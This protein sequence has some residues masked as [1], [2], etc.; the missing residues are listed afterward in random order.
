MSEA[1]TTRPIGWRRARYLVIPLVAVAAAAGL[2]WTRAPPAPGPARAA[3]W[4]AAGYGPA[5]YAAG[6]Q[7]ASEQI[8]HAKERL[9][10]GPPDWLHEEGVA[11]ALISRSR[12]SPDYGDLAQAV[13]VIDAA[14]AMAPPNAGPSLTAAVIG[15]M[16]HRLDK[17]EAA[18]RIEDASAVPPE[19]AEQAEAA[20]LHGDIAFYRGDMASARTWY[21][22]AQRWAPGAGVA[23]RG[24]N[25]AKATGDYD[26]AI[27][28][29]QAAD[30]SPRRSG[31]FQ[32]ASTALQIGAVEQARGNYGAAAAWCAVADRPFP[33]F[34]LFQ[35]HRAQSLAIAGDMRG[36]IAA[37]RKVAREAPSAEVMDALA[38]LLR[39]D[40]QAAESRLWASRAAAIWDT[41]LRQLPQAAYGHALEHELVFGT[42]ARAL[43]LA[44]ANLA[45]RPFGE[46]RLYLASALLMNGQSGDAL[47]QIALAEETGWRS[48]PLYALRAQAFELEG[49]GDEAEDARKA[50]LALNPRIFAPETALVWFSHG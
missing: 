42:P 22:R 2:D 37:M 25:L 5:S 21:D 9:G 14:Q 45:A 48:A 43:A 35:A 4:A 12:L 8:D 6:L 24:A 11:R 38:M 36:A 20:G 47:K 7:S 17:S 44:R 40:G 3:D 13:E 29:F 30:P 49:R 15:M 31:P 26:K 50:A 1:G 16:S 18:L 23:Y 19:A 34:W 46:S 10:Y 27:R 33:G 32:R 28:Q 39:A 41:R